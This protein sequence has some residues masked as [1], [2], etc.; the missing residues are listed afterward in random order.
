METLITFTPAQLVAFIGAVCG[1][2]AS[3]GAAVAVIVKMITKIRAPE[4]KQN[5]RLDDLEK[6]D[7][8]RKKEISEL[9]KEMKTELEKRDTRLNTGDERF[10][11][12]EESNKTIMRGLQ[13]LLNQSLGIKDTEALKKASEELSEFLLNK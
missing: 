9:R 10:E 4:M 11:K 2:I 7:E 6:A 5:Q 1:F 8:A 3:I 12:F 13:A